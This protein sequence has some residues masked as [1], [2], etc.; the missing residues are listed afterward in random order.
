M[1]VLRIFDTY[2]YEISKGTKPVALVTVDEL[3]LSRIKEKLKKLDI[4]FLIQSLDCNKINVFF[5]K[6]ECIETIQTF[7]KPLDMLNPYEDFILGTI[8]GYGTKKQC[9][10]FLKRIKAL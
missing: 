3:C 8:L 2:L 5:G 1:D 6:K 10:R 4:A 7:L 9:E